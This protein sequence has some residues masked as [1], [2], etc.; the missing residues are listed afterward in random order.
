MPNESSSNATAVHCAALALSLTAL[1]ALSESEAA[2]TSTEV[3]D[4]QI[5]DQMVVQASDCMRSSQAASARYGAADIDSATRFAVQAC[6]G[7]LGEFM[8]RQLHQPADKVQAFLTALAGQQ[9]SRGQFGIAGPKPPPTQSTVPA[10]KNHERKPLADMS[11][12]EFRETFK[13]PENYGSD[14]E[15]EMA[16]ARAADWYGSHHSH[17]SAQSFTEFWRRLAAQYKCRQAA[18]NRAVTGLGP[19]PPH[20]SGSYCGVNEDCAV[21]ETKAQSVLHDTWAAISVSSKTYCVAGANRA[22][23]SSYYRLLECIAHQEGWSSD[24]AR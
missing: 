10:L 12:A 4:Q 2:T 21:L 9:L 19:A 17:F 6:G 5:L 3:R 11:E 7:P 13:C 14:G 20:Y 23:D 15:R 16:F 22:H 24:D 8:T 1:F 18:P